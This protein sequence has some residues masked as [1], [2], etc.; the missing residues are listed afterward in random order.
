M[1]ILRQICQDSPAQVYENYKYNFTFDGPSI[2]TL[3]T[4]DPASTVCT[5]NLLGLPGRAKYISVQTIIAKSLD[6]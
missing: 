6:A 2:C 1:S 4:P 5:W 3:S